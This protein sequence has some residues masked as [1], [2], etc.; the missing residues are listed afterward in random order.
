METQKVVLV[1]GVGRV[2]GLGFETARQMAAAGFKV[3][4]N[5]TSRPTLRGFRNL[6]TIAKK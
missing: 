2:E 3:Q 1:T 4:K 5:Y 6:V